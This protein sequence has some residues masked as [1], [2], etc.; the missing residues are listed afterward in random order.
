MKKTILFLFTLLFCDLV[1]AQTG[2]QTKTYYLDN[3]LKVVLCE[4][5]D[6]PEVYGAV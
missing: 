1:S 4:N 2:L 5:H 3:G 6:Q